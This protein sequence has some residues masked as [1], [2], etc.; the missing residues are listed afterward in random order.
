MPKKYSPGGWDWNKE[1]RSAIAR[2]PSDR[3]MLPM[4]GTFEEIRFWPLDVGVIKREDQSSQGACAGH[5]ASTIAEWVRTLATGKLGWQGS[6]A[7]AY[8]ETQRLDGINGDNG[9][10]I[11]NGVRLLMDWG[12]PPEALWP[13]PS[14]YNNRRPSNFDTVTAAAGK[15][16]IATSLNVKTYEGG[17]IFLGSGQGGIHIGI[18]WNSSVNRGLVESYSSGGSGGHAIAALC[19]SKRLDQGGEPYWWIF[20]S[21]T[22]RWGQNGCA[23][24]SPTAIRQ[25]LRDRRTVM[26]G[27]SDMPTQKPRKFSAEDWKR[28]L[29]A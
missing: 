18:G 6:R 17:R 19:L 12:L 4:K 9:S 11:Q 1:D 2:L 14:R 29:A 23:E 20:N 26:I 25:M 10:T 28:A 27:M 3:V 21:W 13:Y 22:K 8:Y 15:N 24:W 16:R 5:S 7:A